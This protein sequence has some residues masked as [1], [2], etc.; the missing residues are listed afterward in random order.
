MPSLPIQPGNWDTLNDILSASSITHSPANTLALRTFRAALA[1]RRTT[2]CNIYCI[3]DSTEEGTGSGVTAAD[4]TKA[5]PNRLAELLRQRFPTVGEP[6][7]Q[8]PNWVPC[9]TSSTVPTGFVEAGTWSAQQLYGGSSSARF[10]AVAG[11]TQSYTI[12]AGVT[13][14][15]IVSLGGGSISGFTFTLDGGAASGTQAL[16]G[17]IRDGVLSR[18]TISD[19]SVSHALVIT[20]VGANNYLGGIIQ[21]TG[22][23]TAGIH[24]YNGG[25]HGSRADNW[26]PGAIYN[27]TKAV[28]TPTTLSGAQNIAAFQT[29]LLVLGLGINDYAFTLGHAA[30]KAS[31]QAIITAARQVYTTKPIPVL[32]LGKYT[33]NNAAGTA[34]SWGDYRN[35]RLEIAKAD[36]QV[37]YLDLYDLMPAVGTTEA[38]TSALYADTLHCTTSGYQMIADAVASFIAP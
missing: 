13:A 25:H 33:P 15:D 19:A 9:F 6:A 30:Y 29:D 38:T 1:G 10:S 2:R 32:L 31:L 11:S 4:R 34:S 27:W 21:Y 3:G 16:G 20:T 8:A 22:N 26:A 28:Q 23:E 17:S 35:A 14:V 5:W 12:P 24:V 36:P 18:V 37:C 7:V